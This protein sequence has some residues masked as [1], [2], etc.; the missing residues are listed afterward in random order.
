MDDAVDFDVAERGVH[1]GDRDAIQCWIVLPKGRGADAVG[2]NWSKRIESRVVHAEWL[3]DARCG[4]LIERHPADSF[5]DESGENEIPI[6]IDG[7][8]AGIVNERPSVDLSEIVGSPL[9]LAPQGGECLEP[10][11]VS[12]D[13]ADGDLRFRR[14]GQLRDIRANG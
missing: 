8:V 9:V 3:P 12:D 4:E 14:V 11:A 13:L 10:R 1:L 5:D 2:R 7:A 6:T